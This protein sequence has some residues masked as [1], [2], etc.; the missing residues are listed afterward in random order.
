MSAVADEVCE[1]LPSSY[2]LIPQL[3]LAWYRCVDLRSLAEELL[4]RLEEVVRAHS[5][6]QIFLIGHSAGGLLAQAIYLQSQ[7]ADPAA[8]L[9]AKARLVLL[10]PLN[11]GWAL[12]HHLPLRKKLAWLVGLVSMPLVR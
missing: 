10:A 6:K 9:L 2:V 12:S 7:K 4:C 8:E 3:P 11:R 1:A 5:Y